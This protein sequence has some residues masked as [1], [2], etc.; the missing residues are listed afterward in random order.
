MLPRLPVPV[1]FVALVALAWRAL[2]HALDLHALES[3]DVQLAFFGWIIPIASWIWSGIQVAGKVTLAALNWSVKLLWTF[4]R[5]T[6]SSMLGLG[7]SVVSLAQRAWSF[8]EGLYTELLAPAWRHFW[9]LLDAARAFL[10]RI[11]RPILRVLFRIR[12][13]VLDVYDRFVRP[14]LDTIDAVQQALRMLSSLGVEWA[15]RLDAQLSK[16]EERITAPFLLVL[17]KV[18]EVI[19]IVNRITTA[20]GLFQRLALVRS[21]ERDM[22]YVSRSFYRLTTRHQTPEELADGLAPIATKTAD[23]H[24]EEL[25]RALTTRD[26]PIAYKA[27]EFVADLEI[28]LRRNRAA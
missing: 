27:D 20:N 12:Q 10:D 9:R 19:N 28:M 4:A 16:L 18:N 13:I 5:S 6:Y 23:E 14:V 8:L 1:W 2:V 26:G 21:I 17:R 15:R 3:A 24:A 25:A 7:K 22:V 11:M